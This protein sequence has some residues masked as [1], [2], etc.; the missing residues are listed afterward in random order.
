[1]THQLATRLKKLYADS[2]L[3][4][5]RGFKNLVWNYDSDD[6]HER[7]RGEPDAIKILKEINGHYTDDPSR[8]LAGFG[9]LKDDGSTTCASW[10][11]CGV[12]PS[13]DAN[14]AARKQPTRRIPWRAAPV[15]LGVASQPSRPL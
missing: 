4:R 14:L 13:P 7:E 5:D 1:L 3:P 2:T 10:I 8:H 11:Y 9:D 15:G 6:P 12:F